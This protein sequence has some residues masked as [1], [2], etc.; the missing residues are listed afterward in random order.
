MRVLKE[1][2]SK[3]SRHLGYLRRAGLVQARKQGLWMH[4]RLARPTAK[5]F[6]TVFEALGHARS[7]FDELKTDLKEFRKSKSC[8][9]GC[10]E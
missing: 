7:E 2:Q 1:P 8:L 5:T 3:V 6:K 10:C 9:V 4:Y